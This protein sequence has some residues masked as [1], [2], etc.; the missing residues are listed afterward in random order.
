MRL[1]RMFLAGEQKK[2]KISKKMTEERASIFRVEMIPREFDQVMGY[3]WGQ[4]QDKYMRGSCIYLRLFVI[5]GKC[6]RTV[7]LV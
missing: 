1:W 5:I 3:Y 7:I 4:I 2:S 6:I